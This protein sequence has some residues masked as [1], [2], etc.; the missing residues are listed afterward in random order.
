MKNIYSTY[1]IKTA[2]IDKF[3]VYHDG[4]E[5]VVEAVLETTGSEGHGVAFHSIRVWK[6]IDDG[7]CHL[8]KEVS[9]GDEPEAFTH[10]ANC[11]SEKI[12]SGYYFDKAG[13]V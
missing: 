6:E 9:L 8:P 7:V 2:L 12:E 5:Y 10:I 3:E 13:A 4:S 1:P 11:I